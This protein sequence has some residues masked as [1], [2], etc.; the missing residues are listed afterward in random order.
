[1]LTRNQKKK[2]RLTNIMS[3][4]QGHTARNWKILDLRTCL[5]LDILKLQGCNEYS[6]YFGTAQHPIE[7]Q[8][9]ISGP[10]LSQLSIHVN[11]VGLTPCTS[12][13]GIGP[14]ISQIRESY[15]INHNTSDW[16]RYKHIVQVPLIRNSK[17]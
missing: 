12:G 3:F 4:S 15:H 10:T 11:V 6:R 1:M 7:L 16:V 9:I 14:R 2:S 17:T 13:G 8:T 5:S